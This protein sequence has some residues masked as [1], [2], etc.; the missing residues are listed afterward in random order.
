MTEVATQAHGLAV[1]GTEVDAGDAAG[2]GMVVQCDLGTLDDGTEVG[3]GNCRRPA[4]EHLRQ[5]AEQRSP[6]RHHG[7]GPMGQ[8]SQLEYRCRARHGCPPMTVAGDRPLAAS[9]A[10]RSVSAQWRCECNA[11]TM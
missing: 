4:V 1:T 3:A 7:L 2:L 8:Q 11:A 9:S 5:T 10:W 6:P